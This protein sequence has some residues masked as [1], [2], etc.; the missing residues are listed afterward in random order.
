MH[1]KHPINPHVNWEDQW[2]IT[3]P[4]LEPSGL[5]VLFSGPQLN[6]PFL[7]TI[8]GL[9]LHVLQLKINLKLHNIEQVTE[10]LCSSVFLTYS[11]RTTLLSIPHL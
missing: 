2:A 7:L 4:A 8:Q 6:F 3:Q 1:G 5:R 11:M 9:V 10:L